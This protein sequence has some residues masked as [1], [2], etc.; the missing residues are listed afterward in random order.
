[1]INE[2]TSGVGRGDGKKYQLK[3]KVLL[4]NQ[5]QNDNIHWL[6][7]K[8]IKLLTIDLMVDISNFTPK[9]LIGVIGH[10]IGGILIPAKMA[11]L[12]ESQSLE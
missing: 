12:A 4:G 7:Y 6:F 2:N 3:N 8:L 9:I 11:R 5:L 1:L 10:G